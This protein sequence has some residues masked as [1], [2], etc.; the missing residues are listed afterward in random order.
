[1]MKVGMKDLKSSEVQAMS[2]DDMPRP[3]VVGKASGDG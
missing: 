3:E 2:N 1:M